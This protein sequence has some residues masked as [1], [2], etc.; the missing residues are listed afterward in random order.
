MG[1][2][3]KGPNLP[4]AG[5]GWE[6]PGSALNRRYSG[7]RRTRKIA[8]NRPFA[9]AKAGR[10]P[11][12][13]AAA[14]GIKPEARSK[15]DAAPQQQQ[16]E[17]QAGPSRLASSRI[18]RAGCI[19]A[20]CVRSYM[21]DG[22]CLAP[23]VGKFFP[24]RRRAACECSGLA[25]CSDPAGSQIGSRGLSHGADGRKVQQKRAAVAALNRVQWCPTLGRSSR[26]PRCLGS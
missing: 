6:C 2:V 22:D 3:R 8:P 1:D 18:V 13:R 4:V 9:V 10:R 26:R 23:P 19:R 16:G 14:S 15:P 25:A 7:G 24:A 17:R 5:R 12:A 21:G 11:S 20:K